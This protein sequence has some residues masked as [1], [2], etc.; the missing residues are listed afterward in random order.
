MQEAESEYG[1]LINN[2]ESTVKE[3][4]EEL[5]EM[6]TYFEKIKQRLHQL[7]VVNKKIDNTNVQ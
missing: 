6:V 1:N 2:A 3:A 4:I 7:L 5:D